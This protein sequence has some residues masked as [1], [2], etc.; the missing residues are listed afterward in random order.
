MKRFLISFFCLLFVFILRAENK[1][2]IKKLNQEIRE[3]EKKLSDINQTK[4]SILN[5]IYSIELNYEKS[6]IESKQLELNLREII[7]KSDKKDQEVQ[8]IRQKIDE[9]R[10]NLRNV[11]R[12]LH[13]M[14]D[15]PHLKILLKLES[16]NQLFKN[17][18]YFLI[19][20]D[21]GYKKIQIFND[22]IQ[23][24]TVLK[25]ELD[26]EKNAIGQLL[27]LKKDQMSHI[28][29]LKQ[30]KLKYI[31]KI[32]EDKSS[33]QQLLNELKLEAEKLNELLNNTAIPKSL[34]TL[35]LKSLKGNLSWPIQGQVISKFGKEKS[36]RFNTYIFNNGIEI[37][38]KNDLQVQAVYSGE[39]VFADY[40]KGY[41]N[42]L[43]IQHAK[44]LYSLYGHC[45]SFF[46][47]KGDDVKK[48]EFIAIAGDTGS[49]YGVSL[50]FE[51]RQN[52]KSE[53]PLSWLFK[54]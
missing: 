53:D 30:N 13:K 3:I 37:K 38:P 51:I 43:I 7:K 29:E 17:Y 16:I 44:N 46:K 11:L 22:L 31:Q 15:N 52:L 50:Y 36:T 25:T 9:N 49:A 23:Q 14:N 10:K 32:N 35:D 39:V 20:I 42:L 27:K 19:I 24:E 54:K 2:K 34:R 18:H 12:I 33:N 6:I 47:K 45:E 5:E 1:E 40:F 4:H 28:V 26:K 8:I 41:G 48:D 21:S